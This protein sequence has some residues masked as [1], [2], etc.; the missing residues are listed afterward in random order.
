MKSQFSEREFEFAFNMEFFRQHRNAIIDFPNIPSQNIEGLVGFDVEFRM[1]IN[2]IQNSIFFQ[3]KIPNYITN[4]TRRNGEFI[5]YFNGSVYYFNIYS[6]LISNQHQ[7]LYN[8]ANGNEN[9]YY[10]SPIFY[11]RESFRTNLFENS[12]LQN[13]ALINV[14]AIGEIID[15]ESH[16]IYYAPGNNVGFFSSIPKNIPIK[17]NF[18]NIQYHLISQKID[19]TYMENLFYKL[20]GILHSSEIKFN[21]PEEIFSLPVSSQCF[22]ILKNYFGLSWI[23]Y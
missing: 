1:N 13:T 20:K 21:F 8:L 22:Y 15:E 3:H 19:D 2:N 14:F 17:F 7:L 23:L 10:T 12:I 4:R 9:V 11:R 6:R 5:D 16:R 18:N